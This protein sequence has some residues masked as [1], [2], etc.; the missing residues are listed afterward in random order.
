MT[1]T[2]PLQ[3]AG[4][5]QQ[6]WRA[7]CCECCYL[8]CGTVVKLA[9]NPSTDF[10]AALTAVGYTLGLGAGESFT[11]KR[12]GTEFAPRKPSAPVRPP[13][14]WL[15]GQEPNSRRGRG[16][17]RR[18][19][20]RGGPAA[21]SRT[22]RPPADSAVAPRGL[23]AWLRPNVCVV[24]GLQFAQPSRVRRVGPV[25]APPRTAKA[26]GA[27]TG[28]V[29]DGPIH[30]GIGSLLAVAPDVHSLSTE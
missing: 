29:R 27:A 21:S 3:T 2:S 4:G 9:K 5:A 22:S 15:Q 10:P 19:L 25:R 1:W 17:S 20:R 18:V 30:E 28:R 11:W 8:S 14:G 23:D 13:T 16:G 7:G 24:T 26:T 6:H 12:S